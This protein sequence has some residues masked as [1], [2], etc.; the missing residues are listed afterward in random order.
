ME[1]IYLNVDHPTV[2]PRRNYLFNNWV[3]SAYNE[4]CA[5]PGKT[6]LKT[7][8][9]LRKTKGLQLIGED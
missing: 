3:W 8:S 9:A 2:N 7:I 6:M 1:S 4:L 5:N